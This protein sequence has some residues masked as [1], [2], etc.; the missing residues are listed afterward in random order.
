MESHQ[1]QNRNRV[2]APE[3][4]SFSWALSK[5]EYAYTFIITNAIEDVVQVLSV[6]V[7]RLPSAWEGRWWKAVN[8]IE[9]VWISKMI[10][11]KGTHATHLLCSAV[12][13][14]ILVCISKTRISL[15][16][17]YIFC[18]H[19]HTGSADDQHCV[20]S[21]GN[22]KLSNKKTLGI[23]IVCITKDI[24]R[25]TVT[26]YGHNIFDAKKHSGVR[27]NKYV[28]KCPKK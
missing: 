19:L 13:E 12:S 14:R 9:P 23:R 16:I 27:S 8:N 22:V 6:K 7:R 2:E 21:I 5:T 3:R 17:Y 26:L 18:V 25:N 15:L 4:T 28:R 24:V 1:T 20:Q 11:R 10:Y